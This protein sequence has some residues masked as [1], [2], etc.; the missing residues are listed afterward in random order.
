M[1]PLVPPPHDYWACMPI[2]YILNVTIYVRL[3]AGQYRFRA[4]CPAVSPKDSKVARFEIND[5]L[6]IAFHQKT[7]H[8]RPITIAQLLKSAST[9][10]SIVVELSK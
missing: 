2:G 3:W 10:E 8:T 9:R 7:T 5:D 4:K 6:H 1:A